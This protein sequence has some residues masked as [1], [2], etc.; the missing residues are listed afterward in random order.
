MGFKRKYILSRCFLSPCRDECPER[1]MLM[2]SFNVLDRISS[3][4]FLH[5]K[6]PQLAPQQ[7]I[8]PKLQAWCGINL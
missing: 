8:D 6:Q 7:L 5:F 2:T 4:V 3:V 1:G